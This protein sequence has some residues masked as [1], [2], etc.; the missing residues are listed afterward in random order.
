MTMTND[1]PDGGRPFTGWHMLAIMVGAFAIIIGVNVFMA[2]KAVGTFPGLETRN[3]YVE[4]QKFDGDRA[5][6]EALGWVIAPTLSGESLMLMI[7]DEESGLPVEVREIGGILGRATHVGDDQEPV[8][9]RTMSGAYVANVG[10][11]DHGKWELRLTA[12]AG[13][14]TNFRRIIELYVPKS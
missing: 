10:T 13:D 4:S 11:L 7:T 1:T 5:A 6:Q 14:G 8:F 12:V 3:S 2:V 9:K